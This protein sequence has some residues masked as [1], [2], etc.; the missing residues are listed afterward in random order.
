MGLSEEAS[1]HVM[2]NALFW[3]KTAHKQELGALGEMYV[4][5]WFGSQGVSVQDTSRLYHKGDLSILTKYG[6]TIRLEVKTA[7][8]DIQN[9]YQFCLRKQG[10]TSIS[11]SDYVVLLAMDNHGYLYRYFVPSGMFGD[12]Q[13]CAIT[14]H[15]ML[16]T[17]K[18]SQFL[19][20]E[21]NSLLQI[22]KNYR[23]IGVK[24]A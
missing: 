17:G 2:S 6:E 23:T 11:H 7:K 16:Y 13:K 3:M 24:T 9:S 21:K 8:E 20:S 5:G 14:S 19:V 18:L 1:R 10:K 15:P 4:K 12:C 22:I